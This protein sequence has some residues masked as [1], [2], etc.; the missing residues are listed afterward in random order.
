MRTH[1]SWKTLATLASLL[2]LGLLLGSCSDALEV[3]TV[4]QLLELSST[5][6]QKVLIVGIDGATF[7]VM[8]PLL[9]AGE[10]PNFARLIE[11]GVK[12][13]LR[14]R[15]PIKSPDIWTTIATGHEREDHGIEDF[16]DRDGDLV[17]TSDRRT[18][19]LWNIT[20]AL[21]R[22]TGFIGW[23]VTWP[24]EPI[25]GYMVSDRMSR[26]RWSEWT[27]S[28][29][30][31]SR[32]FPAELEEEISDLICDPADP[33]MEE[34]D[35]LFDWTPDERSD[36]LTFDTPIFGHG[37]SVVKFAHC[38]QRTY[39]EIALERLRN[40]EQ[41]DLL[42]LF[43]IANDAMS[44]TFWHFYES[45]EYDD[46]DPEQ[47]ARLGSAVPNYYRHND[48]YLGRLLDAVD[49]DTAVLVVSDHGFQPSGINPKPRSSK[50][51]EKL[52][53][54]LKNQVAVGQS[55]M[56]HLD[57]I[58]IAHGGPFRKGAK[59]KANIHDI[60]PTVLALL[61][62]PVAADMEGSVLS[63]AFEPSFFEKHPVQ[64]VETFE[65]VVPRP[66]MSGNTPEV[67]DKEL[68]EQLKALGY[69]N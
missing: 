24:A 49:E 60:T 36:F 69:I 16:R 30:D 64:I 41:P 51:I 54:E 63:E 65:G 7:D 50:E 3:E 12:G 27:K 4:E 10:L 2:P 23:W 38:T 20:T 22:P 1:R 44:H 33:P 5:T 32:V 13:P 17:S 48:A 61:G 14:S 40:A 37:F 45:D 9:D 34:F 21:Q 19:A 43:L 57:G 46:V 59:I 28:K 68:L 53:D 8:E 66:D 42:G 39:E 15:Q 6:N 31:T 29:S 56:H 35:E 52:R 62:L 55:G 26:S 18:L 58:F 47:A 67:E 25:L 11:G